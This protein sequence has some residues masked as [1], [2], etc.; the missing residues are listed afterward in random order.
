MGEGDRTGEGQAFPSDSEMCGGAGRD[1]GV[2]GGE[3][4]G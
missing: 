2:W 1:P 4:R 3:G